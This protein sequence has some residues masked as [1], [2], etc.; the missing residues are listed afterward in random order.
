VRGARL[1]RPARAALW[2]GGALGALYAASAAPGV[3]WWDAGEFIAAVHTLGIPHPPGTP[4]YILVAHAWSMLLPGVDT[5]TATNLL[6]V[7]CTAAAG[8]AIAA[9]VA[10]ALG[11]TWVGV[12]A[13]V[14]A[15]TMSTV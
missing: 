13:A 11:G 1:T 9:L 10:R 2:A 5:A 12:A 3:T 7:V 15:G 4:L 6:S 14:C 8:A